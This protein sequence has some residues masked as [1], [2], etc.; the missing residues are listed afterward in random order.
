MKKFLAGSMV[1][2]SLLFAGG[3]MEPTVVAEPV[4]ETKAWSFE[5]EPYLM[6]TN[7]YG[8]TKLFENGPGVPVDVDFGTILDNLDMAAML[9]ME[10][11]HESGWGMWID[12]G[13]MDQSNDIDSVEG[14]TSVRVRQGV[15]EVMGFY[16]QTL[17]S[18]YIDYLAGM[19]WW[20]NDFELNTIRGNLD[21]QSDWVDGLVGFRYTHILNE[22]WKLRV[23]GD[24]G[25]G[26]A[27]ITYGTSAGVIYTMND[28][29][30]VDVKYKA[31][32]VD[33]EDGTPGLPGQNDYFSY[34]T[35]THGLIVGMNFKF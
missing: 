35:V 7:I 23:H 29:I 32:W 34:D 8:D 25:G 24:I 21:K 4:V 19:R 12:Y 13:F 33:Y 1:L 31:T 11:H 22:N 18:G 16:R 26:G 27:D 10:A 20:D 14:I 17:S 30:D 3:N 15:L 6:V 2:S 5:L 28:F 9:H